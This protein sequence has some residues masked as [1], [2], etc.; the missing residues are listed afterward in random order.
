MSAATVARLKITLDDVAEFLD[1]NKDG[2][3]GTYRTHEGRIGNDSVL[4]VPLK[5][6]L[7]TTPSRTVV[8]GAIWNERVLPPT[9]GTDT[10]RGRGDMSGVRGKPEVRHAHSK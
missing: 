9:A 7:R 8:T 6:A 2:I 4:E 5:S 3:L 10:S 1:F